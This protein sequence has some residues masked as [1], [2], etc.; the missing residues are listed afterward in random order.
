MTSGQ[1]ILRTFG[2]PIVKVSHRQSYDVALKAAY[3]T[4][5][6]LDLGLTLM[7]ARHGFAELN[8]FMRASM[9]LPYH[10]AI[11]KCGIP[12]LICWFIP[13]KLLIPAI[14]LLG[15]VVGWNIKELVCLA[16]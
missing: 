10:L 12:L 2:N 1:H 15:G 5:Q 14:V 9:S 16:F 6:L 13:G 3:L 11:L 8:S 4:L 7:A